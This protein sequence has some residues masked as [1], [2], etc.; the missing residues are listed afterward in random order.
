MGWGRVGD[1]GL[2]ISLGGGKRAFLDEGPRCLMRGGRKNRRT[3]GE[4][5]KERSSLGRK[6]VKN[7]KRWRRRLGSGGTVT[8]GKIGRGS[9]PQTSSREDFLLARPDPKSAVEAS[10]KIGRKCGSG[11]SPVTSW[12]NYLRTGRRE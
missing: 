1:K 2:E 4:K 8:R 11:G 7:P 12:S 10:V 5:R 6:R 9:G 3:R